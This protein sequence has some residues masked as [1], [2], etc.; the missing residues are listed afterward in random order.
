MTSFLHF[1]VSLTGLQ[2]PGG[3]CRM[4]GETEAKKLVAPRGS[5]SS[6]VPTNFQ[7]SVRLSGGNGSQQGQRNVREY[8][9]GA[10]FAGLRPWLRLAGNRSPG[11]DASPSGD[12]LR[13]SPQAFMGVANIIVVV[14]SERLR[15]GDFGAQK[16]NR[17]HAQGFR[18]VKKAGTTHSGETRGPFRPFAFRE[19]N[20]HRGIHQAS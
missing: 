1:Q 3:A 14:L 2:V 10:C 4:A 17:T 20:R 16:R 13:V 19:R 7:K 12:G 15:S 8:C 5:A 9:R 11:N 18:F 6:P